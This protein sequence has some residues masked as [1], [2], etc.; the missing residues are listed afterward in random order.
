MTKQEFMEGIHILQN[1]YNK[2]LSKEQLKLYYENLKDM[3]TQRYLNN[4]KEYIK[5]NNFMPNIAQTRNEPRKQFGNYKQRNYI[6]LD[7]SKFY[8]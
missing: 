6:D 4:I 2:I 7:F 1:N 5:N 8:I 3:N